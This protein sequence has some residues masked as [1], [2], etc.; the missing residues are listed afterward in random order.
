[1]E[2]DDRPVG[3]VLGRRELLALFGVGAAAMVFGCRQ[4]PAPAVSTSCIVRPEQTAGPYFVDERLE[5]SDL[6][7]DPS[8]G[9]VV[10]GLPLALTIRTWRVEGQRCVPLAGA[11]IDLWHCDAAGVYSD[12]ADPGFSTLG[13]KFLRGYQI[14]DAEGGTRFTTIYP[15]WYRGRT[16]HIHLKVRGGQGAKPGFDFT[17]QLYFDDALTD[18]VH[19]RAPYA[20]RGPRTTRNAADAIF[21][22]GGERLLLDVTEGAQGCAATIDIGMIVS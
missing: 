9:A 10:T 15:G 1:M 20:A 19:G 8:D 2:A 14:A 5:R 11:A 16:V 13:R 7:S 12:V 17:S 22:D 3:R 18:R 4:G 6:R 21:R